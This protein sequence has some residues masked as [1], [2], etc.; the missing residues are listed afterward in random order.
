[1]AEWE[2][3]ATI[4]LPEPV[5]YL[6]FCVDSD[7]PPRKGLLSWF[8]GST[9]YQSLVEDDFASFG[10][11]YRNLGRLDP[12]RRDDDVVRW[13]EGF[14]P[15]ALVQP[16]DEFLWNRAQELAIRSHASTKLKE[17]LTLGEL[18][19]AFTAFFEDDWQKEPARDER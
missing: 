17:N 14:N 2:A 10:D 13:L 15:E 7:S 18:N 19:R 4:P 5:V 12:V 8:S 6:L 11:S 1:M 9:P 16:K 3:L